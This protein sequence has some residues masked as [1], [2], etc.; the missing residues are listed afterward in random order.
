MGCQWSDQNSADFH[1]LHAEM[2]IDPVEEHLHIK[3]WKDPNTRHH[4]VACKV[5][6]SLQVEGGRDSRIPSALIGDL[7]LHR[8]PKAAEQQPA[9]QLVTQSADEVVGLGEGSEVKERMAALEREQEMARKRDLLRLDPSCWKG[10]AE[11]GYF[12]KAEDNLIAAANA[13]DELVGATLRL[14]RSL[15]A[16]WHT[17]PRMFLSVCLSALPPL[18][19]PPPSCA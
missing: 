8:S 1:T 7:A 14:A 2:T 10:Y 5:C 11:Q 4:I 9:Q 12:Q 16:Y 17:F 13:E 3:A 6:P 15:V 18:L 19:F